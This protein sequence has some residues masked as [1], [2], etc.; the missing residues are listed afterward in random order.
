M[1][2]RN[3][4]NKIL[5]RRLGIHSNEHPSQ[6]AVRQVFAMFEQKRAEAR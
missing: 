4:A 6:C 3:S 5:D 2:I 1:K